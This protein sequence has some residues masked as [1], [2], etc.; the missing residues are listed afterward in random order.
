LITAPNNR[1]RNPEARLCRAT[2]KVFHVQVAADLPDYFQQRGDRRQPAE[3]G[4][5]SV[6]IGLNGLRKR[7]RRPAKCARVRKPGRSGGVPKQVAYR[8]RQ[9]GTDWRPTV[10]E[11]TLQW[12]AAIGAVQWD[13]LRKLLLRRCL[14]AASRAIFT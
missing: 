5:H 6:N 9:V 8:L 11:H 4:R 13:W 1:R 7:T 10:A 3:H 14:H 2:T 12:R